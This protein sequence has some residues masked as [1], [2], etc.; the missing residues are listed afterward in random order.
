MYDPKGKGKGKG[1]PDKGNSFDPAKREE[2][3]RTC[4][5]CLFGV[6]VRFDRRARRRLRPASIVT[7][8]LETAALASAALASAACAMRVASYDRR[9]MQERK[10][11]SVL[12][13]SGHLL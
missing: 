13:G 3:D 9:G 10:M 2:P 4:V 6:C 11:I 7:T 12:H 1:N 8:W 5:R